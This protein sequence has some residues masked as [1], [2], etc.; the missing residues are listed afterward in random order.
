MRSIQAWSWKSYR[1]LVSTAVSSPRRRAAATRSR[2]WG[3]TSSASGPSN[4]RAIMA[5][6]PGSPDTA[7]T[8]AARAAQ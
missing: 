5:G 6:T 2:A 8:S 3:R 4:S 7:A 1:S